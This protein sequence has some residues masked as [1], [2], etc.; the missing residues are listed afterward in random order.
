MSVPKRLYDTY[1]KLFRCQI[2]RDQ[3]TSPSD[4]QLK[5]L[6]TVLNESI[7]INTT[8]DNQRY[9]VS[10]MYHSNTKNFISYITDKS[11]RVGALVLWTECRNIVIY[12]RLYGKAHVSWNKDTRRYEV[13]QFKQELRLHDR[14]DKVNKVDVTK[15]V[16]SDKKH[17]TEDHS[18]VNEVH[19]SS[20]PSEK[21][22]ADAVKHVATEKTVNVNWGDTEV[23]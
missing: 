5:E 13:Q 2:I 17:D 18:L 14:I 8:E 7:P 1:C 3:L 10:Q 19:V 11:N 9:I 16:T 21:T 20:N 4:E 22:Y 12:F 6:E 15:I 23:N